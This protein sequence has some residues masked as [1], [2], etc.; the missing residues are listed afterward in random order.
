MQ[1]IVLSVAC[2]AVIVLS[3][4]A[5]AW[6]AGYHRISLYPGSGP[7]ADSRRETR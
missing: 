1:A 7:A 2:V 3:L 4:F 5:A 6:L